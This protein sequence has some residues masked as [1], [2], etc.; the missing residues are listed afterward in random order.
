MINILCAVESAIF[1]NL[2]NYTRILIP[3]VGV[4]HDNIYASIKQN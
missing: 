1:V 4:I 3:I 2:K